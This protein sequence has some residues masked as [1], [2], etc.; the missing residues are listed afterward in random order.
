MNTII[1]P[2]GTYVAA[3]SLYQGVLDN[4]AVDARAF[5]QGNNIIIGDDINAIEHA[6][7]SAQ[8]AYNYGRPIAEGMG[9]V[10][11]WPSDDPADSWKDE[12]NNE[13]GRRIAEWARGNGY[14][15]NDIDRLILDAYR[16]GPGGSD[17]ILSDSDPRID[18]NKPPVPNW[19][20]PRQF[21]EDGTPNPLFDPSKWGTP[22]DPLRPRDYEG[23][24]N[25]L[26][27]L[28]DWLGD[29]LDDFID[30]LEDMF[31]RAI[32]FWTDDDGDI[33]DELLRGIR[34]DP[35]VLDL[36]GDGIELTPLAASTTIFD[37]DNDLFA[38]R[39]GWVSPHDG[40]LVHDANQNDLVRRR[41]AVRQRQCRRL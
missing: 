41:R 6:H 23:I 4:Q 24:P 30:W 25:A 16:G 35:I 28:G 12:W 32:D 17:L 37:L 13:V 22:E 21:L 36:D 38:E 40:L 18:L 10:K 34:S 19:N 11:E 15:E 9:T 3:H 27:D 29:R 7:R 8:V 1:V 14:S 39:T 33:F 2:T 20:A 5:A 26:G 31:D